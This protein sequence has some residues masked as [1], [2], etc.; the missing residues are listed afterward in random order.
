MATLFWIMNKA[1]GYM[2]AVLAVWIMARCAISVFRSRYEPEV[3]GYL[4]LPGKASQPVRHWECILGRAGASD[5]V[6]SDASVARSHAAIQRS[7]NGEWTVS[8]LGSRTGVWVNGEQVRDTAPLRSGDTLRL[9]DVRIRFRV[10]SDAQREKLRRGSPDPGKGMHPEFT[11]LLLTLFQMVVLYQQLQA[12]KVEYRLPIALAFG[13]LIV[14]EWAA[15]LLIRAVTVRGFVPET[16]A[17]LLT[18]AG[19]SVAASSTPEG[20]LKQ[21]LLFLGGLALFAVLGTWLRDLRRAKSIRWVMAFAAL[22]FLALNLLLSERIWGAKNWLSIAGQSLQPSEFVKIA[23]VYAGAA[24]LDRLF[25]KRNLLLFIA[26]SAVVVGALALMG[27][28]GTALVFF[29]C[30]LVI[31]YLRSGSFATVILAVGGAALAVMLILT[32]KPYVAARFATWGHAWETPLAGGFQQVRAMSAAAAGGLFG[33]GGGHGWLRDVVA[34]DTDLV[35]AVVCEELGLIVAVCC[36][37][38]LLLLAIFSFRSAA[39]SRSSFYLIASCAT[40][41]I[42]MAQAALNVFG[43]LD[44]L[45][46]TGVTFPFVSRGG[47]SLVSCWTMM[48][49]ILAGDTRQNAA[50]PRPG[51]KEEKPAAKPAARQPAAKTA[52]TNARKTP[53]KTPAKAV[54][55]GKNK[56]DVKTKPAGKTKT[57][58][59]GAG[60]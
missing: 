25:R 16:I 21:C 38:G 13:F 20:M 6:L 1:S 56:P 19:F 27:D 59:K 44:L 40:V 53:A 58:G 23:F 3:W 22:G 51:G 46:F 5:I 50:A 54:S 2:L 49:F 8:D 47:S 4:E 28:F 45:P 11:L 7:D 42:F 26:F 55:A 14:L 17:L 35:F 33:R 9:G 34:A 12:A 36:V 32:V 39:S 57:A 29:I 15:L 48:A 37:A 31:S 60:K 30:F 43:S 52:G 10:L 41:T 18:T 24:T